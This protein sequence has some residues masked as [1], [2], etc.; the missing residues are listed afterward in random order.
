M[1][2]DSR[3]FVLTEEKAGKIARKIE[4]LRIKQAAL[5]T[6]AAYLEPY[7]GKVLNARVF[8]EVKK[9]YDSQNLFV[10]FDWAD[11]SGALELRLFG[12]SLSYGE[13]RWLF[14]SNTIKKGDRLNYED[15]RAEM[16][17][18]IDSFGSRAAEAEKTLKTL[19]ST[20]KKACAAFEVLQKISQS[21]PSEIKD[22][23][24][25]FREIY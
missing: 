9:A 13:G 6:I 8:K 11:Y 2:I 20:L 17:K 22:E 12:Q 21:L 14:V 5:A 25:I 18:V 23:F 7:N 15:L 24:K 10:C 16:F 3:D 19:K 4:V 1:F